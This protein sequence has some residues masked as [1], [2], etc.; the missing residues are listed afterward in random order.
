MML[1]SVPEAL[2]F[3][4]VRK[5]R[6]SKIAFVDTS[7]DSGLPNEGVVGV[8]AK[9]KMGVGMAFERM[10]DT[11]CFAEVVAGVRKVNSEVASVIEAV[12][13]AVSTAGGVMWISRAVNVDHDRKRVSIPKRSLRVRADV[14]R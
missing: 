1:A 2:V 6:V 10:D 13:E 7:G 14:S 11:A 3:F 5:A 4:P 8:N 12:V 9:M